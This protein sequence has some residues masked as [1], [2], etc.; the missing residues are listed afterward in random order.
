MLSDWVVEKRRPWLKR[1]IPQVRIPANI[2]PHASGYRV[3][4]GMILCQECPAV[5]GVPDRF[6]NPRD[7]LNTVDWILKFDHYH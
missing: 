7:Y 4:P 1:K 5:S 2:N 3:N 6:K